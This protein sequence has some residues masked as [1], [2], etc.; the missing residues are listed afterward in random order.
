MINIRPITDLKDKY[1]EIEERVLKRGE[2]VYLTKNGY[3]SMALVRL[4]KYSDLVDEVDMKKQFEWQVDNVDDNEIITD[5]E[6]LSNKY[7]N[8]AAQPAKVRRGNN[9]KKTSKIDISLD[10]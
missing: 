5:D 3:G 2:V 8:N 1:P 7:W 4:E 10:E 9:D 6:V